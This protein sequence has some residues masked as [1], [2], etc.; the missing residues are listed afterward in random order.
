MNYT[1]GWWMTFRHSVRLNSIYFKDSGLKSCKMVRSN[2]AP[3]NP[4]R[5]NTHGAI[6]ALEFHFWHESVK[7]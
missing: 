5:S 1:L 4:L 2:M 3:F 6:S 7:M